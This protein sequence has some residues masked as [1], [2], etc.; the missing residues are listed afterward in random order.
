MEALKIIIDALIVNEKEARHGGLEDGDI[1][2]KQNGAVQVLVG[3][4]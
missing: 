3:D 4:K 1:Y 2:A